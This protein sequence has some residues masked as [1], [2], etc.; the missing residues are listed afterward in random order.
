MLF[1][2]KEDFSENEKSEYCE[3][4]AKAEVDFKHTSVVRTMYTK[5]KVSSKVIS[6]YVVDISISKHYI[7]DFVE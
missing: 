4:V 2:L 1:K 6:I 3:N 7:N 5:I